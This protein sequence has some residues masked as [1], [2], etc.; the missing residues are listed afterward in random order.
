MPGTLG[1][2]TRRFFDVLFATPLDSGERAAIEGWLDSAQAWVFFSQSDPDQRHG[3]HAALVSISGGAGLEVI[4][5]A[6]LHDVGKR[7]ARLGVLG[8]S[9]ASMAIRLG[10]PLPM[11]W[12]LYRDHGEIASRELAGLGYQGLIV[13]FAR[14][15]HGDQPS[16]FPTPTWDLLQLADQPPKTGAARAAE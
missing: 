7:H 2:L 13:E 11:R 3:F 14:H 6:L 9:V 12:R 16:G 8:R 4:R 1:H 5:A 10:L 15:H